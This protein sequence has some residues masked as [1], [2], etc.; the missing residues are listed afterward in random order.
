MT[1][2]SGQ[3]GNNDNVYYTTISTNSSGTGWS[4]QYHT[5][6]WNPAPQPYLPENYVRFEPAQYQATWQ[7]MPKTEEQARIEDGWD[8]DTNKE[9]NT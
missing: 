7:M 2:Y 1:G 6:Q 3:Y 8:P 5:I 9:E 4:N